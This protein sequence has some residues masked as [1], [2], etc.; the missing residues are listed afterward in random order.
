MTGNT[1]NV[2]RSQ[3]LLAHFKA[4]ADANI[5]LKKPTKLSSI[6][7][8]KIQQGSDYICCNS[9]YAVDGDRSGLL[10]H[11]DF[12]CA[13]SASV[14]NQQSWWA[15]D[16]Q[17]VYAINDV[18]IFGRQ[19]CCTQ[20]LANFDVEII[21][22]TCRCNHWDNLEEGDRI[23]C[24]YQKTESQS[25]TV[26]CPPNTKGRFGRY[27]YDLCMWKDWVRICR[28]SCRNIYCAK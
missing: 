8:P 2:N 24:H 10:V 22:P 13:H 9:T 5:A 21:L 28:S 27:C 1:R 3:Q 20:N 25:M 14:A 26:T 16:L 7:D 6:F 15:V 23:N 4:F 19:D 18:D 11:S 12:F 17:N